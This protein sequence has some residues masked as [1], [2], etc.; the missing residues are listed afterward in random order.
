MTTYSNATLHQKRKFI[1]KQQCIWS[2]CAKETEKS[3]S[4]ICYLSVTEWKFKENGRREWEQ[5]GKRPGVTLAWANLCE[6]I[7]TPESVMTEK[8]N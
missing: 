4:E 1:R 6:D 7:F 2:F 3:L 5:G 8:K